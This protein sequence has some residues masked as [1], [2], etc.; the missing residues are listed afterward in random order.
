MGKIRPSNF[1]ISAQCVAPR[2]VIIPW[3]EPEVRPVATFTKRIVVK[4]LVADQIA[5]IP[6][7]AE[8]E[9]KAVNSDLDAGIE[10][11]MV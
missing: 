4:L 9:A 7:G 3:N 6:I 8:K 2:E 10:K 1:L 5:V 11:N